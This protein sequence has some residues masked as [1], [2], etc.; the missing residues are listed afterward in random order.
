VIRYALICA[1]AHEFE[2]W[3]RDIATFDEQAQSGALN[4][5]F[6]DSTHVQKRVMAPHVARGAQPQ[7]DIAACVSENAPQSLP[8]PVEPHRQLREMIND[9]REKVLATTED[10]GARFP[11]EARKMQDGD[12]PRRAIRGKASLA[13][14]KALIEEGV[15]VLPLPGEGH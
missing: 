4:C 14:A 12:A 8:A 13:E 1:A 10:V 7:R 9:L 11:I 5:P 6:C 3:F 2:A 15:A